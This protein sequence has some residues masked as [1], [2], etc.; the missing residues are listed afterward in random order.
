MS[1]DWMMWIESIPPT[2][3]GILIG[4]LFTVIGVVLTNSSNTKRLRLQH[5]HERQLES[6][7]RDLNL[8]REVYLGAMEALSAGMVVIGRFSDLEHKTQNLMQVYLDKSPSIARVNLIGEIETIEAVI[9]FTQELTATFLRLASRR[10]QIYALQKNAATIEERIDSSSKELDH[11]HTSLHE[12]ELQHPQDLGQIDKHHRMI[13]DLQK[14]INELRNQA[15]EIWNMVIPAQMNLVQICVSE[16]AN[17][18]HLL[19]PIF[20]TMRAELGLGF[21]EVFYTKIIEAGYKQQSEYLEG[22]IRD[23]AHDFGYSD[24]I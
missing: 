8:R 10:E 6:R 14:N 4:S 23:L 21:D 5:D 19:I 9:R 11:L 12:L 22:Y 2:F 16:Q 3:W 18:E 15:D 13:E 1:M 17:L 24:I 7:E 20:R